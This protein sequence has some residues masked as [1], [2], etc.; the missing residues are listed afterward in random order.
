MNNLTLKEQAQQC[1][2]NQKYV[3]AIDCY[4]QHLEDNPEDFTSYCY[5]GLAHFMQEEEEEAENIWM[6]ILFEFPMEQIDEN[7]EELINIIETQLIKYSK[8]NEI[9]TVIKLYHI[10]KNINPDYHHE[11]I[12]N[13]L[14]P[15]LNKFVEEAISA[16]LLMEFKTAEKIY[17]RILNIDDQRSEAWHGLGLVYY[18]TKRDEEA[19][20][21]V[22]NAI[23]LEPD[24]G[25]YYY[26]LALIYEENRPELA[27][28]AYSKAI[29]LDRKLP[30]AFTRLGNLLRQSGQLEEARKIYDEGIKANPDDI[31]CYVNLGNLLVELEDYQGAISIYENLLED[32]RY[33]NNLGVFK[34][35]AVALEKDKQLDKALL[36][37]AKYNQYNR[38]YYKAI[39][40]YQEYLKEYQGDVSVYKE[41]GSCY[42]QMYLAQEEIDTYKQGIKVHPDAAK[43]YIT[44]IL[45]YQRAGQI[46]DALETVNK[47]L[48]LFPDK[49]SFHVLNQCL[50][51]TIYKNVE[52]FDFYRQRYI[53]LLD[54]L[55]NRVLSSDDNK[56]KMPDCSYFPHHYYMN[57]RGENDLEIQTKYGNLMTQVMQFN[58]PQWSH[59]LPLPPLTPKKKIKVGYISA[60]LSG[61]GILGLGW[62][63][64][65]DRS[66]FEIY[67]YQIGVVNDGQQEQFNIYSDYHYQ[68]EKDIDVICQQIRQDDLHILIM[69]DIGLEVIMYNL[70]GL[71]LAPIQCATWLHPVT[72]GYPTID[73]FIGSDGMEPENGQEH[74]TEQLIRLPKMGICYPKPVLP[75]KI[76]GREYFN[77]KENSVIYLCCQMLQKYL[78]QHDDI[79]PLIAQ[80]VPNAQFIF[81]EHISKTV[82]ELFS[83][84]LTESFA[85]YN[86]NFAEHCQILEKRPK[87]EYFNIQLV[88]DVFLDTFGWSAGLTALDAIACCLPI[89]SCPGEMMRNRQAT[90]MLE[91]INV[92]ETIPTNKQEYIDLAI[93]LGTNIEWRNRIKQKIKVNQNLIFND[94]TPVKSLEK[95]YQEA[96]QVYPNKITNSRVVL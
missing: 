88:S 14:K 32:S 74:Y 64:N 71:R 77:F 80:Q 21:A 20:N 41:L 90:G 9:D 45:A 2:V 87:K 92:T 67:S 8:N 60:R 59:N 1:F 95:F 58:Y 49:L 66:K 3:E 75:E 43:L 91:M 10:I 47:A 13:Q 26:S 54:E 37:E 48:K 30:N 70:A 73:Y 19:Y 46:D 78:P 52:D 40:K 68:L 24:K 39:E 76:Q 51:P 5:L 62:L 93:K 6:S 84:R 27:F 89:V 63:K 81:F 4:Q 72:T 25:L 50:L 83:T 17:Q 69:V 12:V 65:C 34:N 33:N 82:M 44:L 86:L 7:T 55:I 36:Y 18:Q 31:G 22:I 29:E 16:A 23:N 42:G 35:L 61:I 79:F 11:E 38:D 28:S 96:V 57:Y 53:N 15:Y 94:I 85:K 56:Q